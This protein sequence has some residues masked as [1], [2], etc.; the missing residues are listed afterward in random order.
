MVGKYYEKLGR[1]QQ[2]VE[3]PSGIKS[4]IQINR[5][6]PKHS[7]SAHKENIAAAAADAS[8][9]G[10]AVDGKFNPQTAGEDTANEDLLELFQAKQTIVEEQ[11][12][13]L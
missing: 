12:L 7:L 13:L 3:G 9:T 10:G 5:K 4:K 6:E 1:M 11:K 8:A 2:L